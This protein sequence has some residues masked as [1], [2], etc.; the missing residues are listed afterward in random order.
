MILA[1]GNRSHRGFQQQARAIAA[2][3]WPKE[4]V[5]FCELSRSNPATIQR[6]GVKGVILAVAHPEIEQVYAALAVPVQL[7]GGPRI[8]L[9]APILSDVAGPELVRDILALPLAQF[10]AI[11][12]CLTNRPFVEELR[13]ASVDQA[14]PDIYRALLTL[15]LAELR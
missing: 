2:T 7:V 5:T 12:R 10:G 6:H 14:S 1:Y 3:L 8:Q 11:V 13:V 15:R 4:H 9:S